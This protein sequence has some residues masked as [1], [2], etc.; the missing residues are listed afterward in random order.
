MNVVA[1]VSQHMLVI[2]MC[3]G[4]LTGCGTQPAQSDPAAA[5]QLLSETLEAWKSGK[6]PEELKSLAPP[7]YVGDQRWASGAKLVDFTITS[8]GEYHQSSVRIPV[9][10]K[11]DKDAKP[12]EVAY[13]VST[14]PAKSITLAE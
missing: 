9:R 8:D 1:R 6:K 11:T 3:C 4:C 10:M 2:G 14:N 5:K 12:R 7:V 13:W